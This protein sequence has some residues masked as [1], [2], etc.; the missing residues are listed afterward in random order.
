MEAAGLPDSVIVSFSVPSVFRPWHVD[1][2]VLEREDRFSATCSTFTYMV[3]ELMS[4]A[5][6]AATTLGRS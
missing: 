1:D 5:S 4:D 2:E 6:P 3:R